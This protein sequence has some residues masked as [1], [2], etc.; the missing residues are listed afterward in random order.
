MGGVFVSEL[1]YLKKWNQPK[2]SI[3]DWENIA[4]LHGDKA[5]W[6]NIF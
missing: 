3:G 5:Y 6:R 4:Y 1:K 2:H